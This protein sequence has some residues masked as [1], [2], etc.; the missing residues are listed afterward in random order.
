MLLP[1]DNLQFN[2][3]QEAASRTARTE[4]MPEHR[5]AI[6]GLGLAGESGEVA[7]LIKKAL[8]HGHPLDATAIIEELGDVLWYISEICS[9]LDTQLHSVA[10]RNIVKLK[11]RYPRGF[12]S[13]QS[14]NRGSE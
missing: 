9:V 8:G 2:Q 1:G 6:A 7:D 5:L 13:Q 4:M 14:I 3:Y 12:D 11:K 10:M